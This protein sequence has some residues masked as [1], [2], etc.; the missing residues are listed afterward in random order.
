MKSRIIF[1]AIIIVLGLL[2][3]IGPQTIF[4]TC[5]GRLQV[6]DGRVVDGQA[7]IIRQVPMR[8]HWGARAMIG[9]G[10]MV[11]LLGLTTIAFASF[12]TRLGLAIGTLLS[13]IVSLLIP[14]DVLIG[15]C[16]SPTMECRTGFGPGITA[17]SI[18]LIIVS[19]LY[20]V[21]LFRARE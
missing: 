11:T 14:T 1:G 16:I 9:I 12:K 19:A 18:L 8:C 17:I 13:G 2:A 10:G 5:Q 15:I 6:T 7:N 4:E 20:M 3:A 21:F